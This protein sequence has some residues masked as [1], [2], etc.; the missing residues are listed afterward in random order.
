MA[1]LPADGNETDSMGCTQT[2]LSCQ[3]GKRKRVFRLDV[4]VRRAGQT[5]GLSGQ[6]DAGYTAGPAKW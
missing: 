5:L 2:M 6:E 1:A 4:C 3:W